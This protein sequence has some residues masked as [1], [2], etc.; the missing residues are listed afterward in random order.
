ME[1]DFLQQLGI[2]IL[3]AMAISL[4]VGLLLLIF[5]VRLLKRIDVP[6]GADF[7]ETLLYTPLVVV[8]TIDL[9]DFALDILSAPLSWVVLD[10]LGL[11]AL[12]GV[13]AVEGL[14]PLTQFLPTMTLC[15]LGA[16]FLGTTPA[17][18]SKYRIEK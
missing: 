7:T 16:R 10:R 14:L 1:V 12:R 15:W 9:L 17:S 8:I 2:I 3:A 4:I 6:A 18:A 5:V 11:K 13:A